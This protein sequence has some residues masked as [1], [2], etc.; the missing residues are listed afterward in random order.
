VTASSNTY[1]GVK[2]RWLLFAG[3]FVLTSL[4]FAKPLVA[5]VR[6]S[7]SSDDVSYLILI[8]FIGGLV[9]F[10]ERRQIILHLS[11]DK[12]FSGCLLTLACFVMLA[13]LLEGGASSLDLQLSGYI[14]SLVLFWVAG[15]IFL[16]GKPAF[17]AGYFP[18]LFLFLMV[19]PPQFL[20]D[21]VIQ[22]LQTGSAWVT[23]ALF[24]LLGVPVL[25]E[26]F[27]FHLASVNIEVAKECSGI[28]SSMA[29][30]IL[31]LLV[32]HFHLTSFW[33]KVLFLACGLLMM[34]LKNGIRIVCL[35]LLAM[36]VDPGFLYGRLHH[37]GGIFF[38]ILSLLLLWPILWL[39]QRGEVAPHGELS[40]RAAN[41]LPSA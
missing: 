30:L 8:P 33:K 25:R 23:G 16:F 19:P 29:L 1:R 14:L 7:L 6:M 41:K 18:L 38:F 12:V 32:A 31:A 3:W 2:R 15:F 37:H 34:I 26:G 21:H 5:L 39:L 28:R 13:S 27:V 11:Y 9:L 17:K 35:T 10:I 24:D 40:L 36:H 20:L 22:I 4:L